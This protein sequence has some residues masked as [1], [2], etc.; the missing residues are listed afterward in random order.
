MILGGITATLGAFQTGSYTVTRRAA[1][2][3]VPDGRMHASASSTLTIQASVQPMNGRE[4][5]RLPEGAR[6][7][8]R[9]NVYTRTL[10]QVNGAPDVVTIDGRDYEVESIQD[11]VGFGADFYKVTVARVG[12]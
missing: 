11:Y 1:P 10:L 9:K 6:V 5:Q 3:V 2:G 12:D 8:E 7:A 4:L